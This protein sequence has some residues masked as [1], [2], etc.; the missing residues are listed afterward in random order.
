[1]A[2]LLLAC[3]TPAFAGGYACTPTAKLSCHDG[4]CRYE[5]A[6]SFEHA[7]SF[8]YDSDTTLLGACLWTA[9]YE[10]RATTLDAADGIVAATT[11]RS[12]AGGRMRLTLA[13]GSDLRF[14]AVW[15]V[16]GSGATLDMGRCDTLP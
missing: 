6:G 5:P 4:H 9:C 12:E 3:T 7:G 16:A 10:G 2:W 11:L 8:S 14:T 15:D 13:I 1:M